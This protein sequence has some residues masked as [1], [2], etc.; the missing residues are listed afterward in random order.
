MGDNVTAAGFYSTA[1]GSLASAS[2]DYSTAIGTQVVAA[3]NY[4]TALGLFATAANNNSAAIGTN[5]YAGAGGAMAIGIGVTSVN[6]MNNSTANSLGVG[7]N[8]T[9]PTLF[10]VPARASARTGRSVSGPPR[11]VRRS[12]SK[13]SGRPTR[14]RALKSRIQRERPGCSSATM[15]RSA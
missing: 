1:L 10:V 8:S 12:K 9:V 11:P 14:H 4:A 7:F 2:V 3:G 6:R 15:P 13:A 5:V